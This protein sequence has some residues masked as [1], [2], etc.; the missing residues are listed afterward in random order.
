MDTKHLGVMIRNCAAKYNENIA[1]RVKQKD[2]WEEIT[3]GALGAKVRAAAMALID[4]GVGEGDRVG[5]FAANRPE[6]SIADFGI[7]STR[8]VTVPIYAT[9]TPKQA[10][11]I[12]KDAGLKILFAGDAGQYEKICSIM[13]GL[14]DLQKVIVFDESITLKNS[15]SI[16]FREFLSAGEKSSKGAELDKRLA[17][18]SESDLATII[19][20]SGTTGEPKG[21][22]LTHSNI[23]HQIN[24]IAEHFDV[25]SKD[26][27][28]CFIP[29]SHAYERSWSFIVFNWGAQNNYLSDTKKLIEYVQEVRPT[30][31]VGVPRVYEKIY[32][33]IYAKLEKAPGLKKKLFTWAVGTGKRYAFRKKDKSFVGPILKLQW[34]IAD[35]LVLGKLREVVGGPKNFFSAGGAPL[36]KEIEEFFFS[37]GLLVCQGYGLTETSPVVTCNRPADFKFGTVGK[38]IRDTE[39]RIDNNGEV[40]VRGG[41]LMQGYFNKP[42]AT[43]EV[44]ENG[45]FRTGD[46][47]IIDRDGFLLITGRIKEIIIT[48]QG[49]NIAPL[50]IET[51]VGKDYYIEQMVV[52]GD[53]RKYITALIVPAFPALEEYA[54]ERNIPFIGREDLVGNREIIDFYKKRIED[55]S[56][57]LANYE[58]IKRFTLMPEE[59]TQEAGEMTPTMK[60]KRKVVEAKY[61][62][63][64]DAMY[65][66][67][68]E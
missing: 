26:R 55:S 52:I 18:A 59:F 30:A 62:S 54:K 9:N 17:G 8:G 32:A 44:I 28:L 1:M 40:L 53:K 41:N 7:L 38:P 12:I 46:V 51:M 56:V 29:L 23:F 16:T 67:G 4:L 24:G 33:T 66:G 31:M 47:G 43:A 65:E 37:L 64:I 19:Y 6:W 14:K 36:A 50:H 13:D 61:Q 42:E 20:T 45:W 39:V 60:I 49:K 10:E 22:M 15:K 2:R 25:S 35:R 68:E 63:V 27:S 11:Y 58:S 34:I 21:V 57:E 3:Y 48:S 5:I